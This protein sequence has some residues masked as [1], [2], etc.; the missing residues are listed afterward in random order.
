MKLIHDSDG[1]DLVRPWKQRQAKRRRKLAISS[2]DIDIRDF[3]GVNA[4]HTNTI[5]ASQ[6]FEEK[7]QQRKKTGA[8]DW[9]K[10]D[11]E[12]ED[13][14]REA[15]IECGADGN[16]RNLRG[17]TVRQQS[18]S[19]SG[20]SQP[21]SRGKTSSP[22]GLFRNADP[23]KAGSSSNQSAV[24]TSPSVASLPSF[25][26]RPAPRALPKRAQSTNMDLPDYKQH[27]YSLP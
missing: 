12:V 26:V 27:V 22:S 18:A 5:L 2:C 7:T 23:P 11:D 9:A 25:L 19:A 17:S 4:V 14:A 20:P 13:I 24:A 21:S 15:R 8:A 10:W 16:A 1:K 3:R 6:A